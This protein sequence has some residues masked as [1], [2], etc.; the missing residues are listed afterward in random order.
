MKNKIMYI[1]QP[2]LKDIIQKYNADPNTFCVEIE[3]KNCKDISDYLTEA[4]IKLKFPMISKGIDG[5][6]DWIRDLWW[7]EEENIVL[8]I[9]HYKEFLCNDLDEK[10][11]LVESFEDTVFPR[12]ESEVCEHVVEGKPRSFMVYLIE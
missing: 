11:M 6:E 8:V 1:N 10:R 3:G 5:Y 2:A 7:I 4:S 9:N 12:W